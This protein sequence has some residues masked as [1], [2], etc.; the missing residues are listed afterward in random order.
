MEASEKKSQAD[1]CTSGVEIS[2]KMSSPPNG[3]DS[4]Q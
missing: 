4:K 2:R 1:S 3:I